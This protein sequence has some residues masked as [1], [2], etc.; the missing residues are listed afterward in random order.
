MITNQRL[1]SI[2][3]LLDENLNEDTLLRIFLIGASGLL[4][5]GF[6]NRATID[7]DVGAPVIDG[8]LLKA[9]TTVANKLDLPKNW[10]NSAGISFAELLPPGWKKR[11]KPFFQGSHIEVLSASRSDLIK[12]KCLAYFDREK[13]T[14]LA[15]LKSLSVNKQDLQSAKEWLLLIKEPEETDRDILKYIDLLKEVLL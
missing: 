13:D 11:A 5:Q 7:I 3:T 9:T 14:D 1:N 6:G 12:L 4:A 2:F 15:D 8:E 10:L